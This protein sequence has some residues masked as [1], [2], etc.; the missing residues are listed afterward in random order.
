MKTLCIS[1]H[2][3]WAS[4]IAHGLKGAK[5]A[6]CRIRHRGLVGIH[7]CRTR[8]GQTRDALMDEDLRAGMALAGIPHDPL[9]PE[10]F[11]VG[12]PFGVVVGTAELY[13]CV[14][15]GDAEPEVLEDLR[16]YGDYG[17]G[18]HVWL[19]RDARPLAE[20]YPARGN[21]VPWRE[22]LPASLVCGR[23]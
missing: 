23:P 16:R 3:P 6:P 12:T 22:D 14:A 5:A 19:F 4:L 11:S 8:G 9:S 18:S 13:G 1:V 17:P 7:A 20:P 21:I 2:Q 10:G 15:V